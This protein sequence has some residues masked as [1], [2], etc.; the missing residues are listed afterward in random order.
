MTAI[1][2][3]PTGQLEIAVEAAI[4]Q[5]ASAW[6]TSTFDYS[7]WSSETIGGWI[8]I[9][10]DTSEVTL[11]SG[12]SGPDGLLTAINGTTGGLTLHGDQYNPW[13]PPWGGVVGP[14]GPGVP[15]RVRWRHV[16]DAAFITAFTG[17]SDAWP[18]DR[19]EGV[20]SVP[21]LDATGGL[22]NLTLPTLPAPVGQ[23][24]ALS[25]R[26]NRILDAAAW[27]TGL[28]QIPTDGRTVI[29]T[30]LG[31]SPWAMLQV[32]TDT[33]IGLLWV[34][35][36]GNVA[37]L[38][39]GQAGGWVPQVLAPVLSDVHGSNPNT[40]CVVNFA[41][42]DPVVVRNAVTIS[43]AADPLVANDAPVAAVAIDQASVTQY[44]PRTYSRDDLIHD[45]DAWSATL[46][47]AVLLDGAW[48]G[49]HPQVATLD[50]RMDARVADL[51]LG[52]EIGQ[53]VNVVDSGQTFECAV[54]GYN[55]DITR[56][57]VTGTLILSDV[58]RWIGSLWDSAGWDKSIWSI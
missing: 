14:L 42:S 50:Q 58:S 54:V 37:Y 41:N 40:L 52:A 4:G 28:R 25:A 27:P 26:M 12:A 34:T 32:A 22:A 24:E 19:D 16:G 23:H 31:E 51:L 38:P 35:R 56:N 3:F 49:L 43:R 11:T 44:G 39:V 9:S 15:C 5:G 8:D 1:M 7:V 47:G 17:F 53:V 48:P 57:S 2:D 45:T 18:F 13:A 36:T 46:A 10:C 20:A 30:V 6:D 33:G 55:V 21:V 29:S